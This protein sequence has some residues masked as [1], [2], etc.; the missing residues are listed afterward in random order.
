MDCYSNHSHILVMDAL[1]DA[2]VQYILSYLQNAK[3]IARC[4]CVSKQWKESISFIRSLYFSRSTFE[5]KRTNRDAIIGRMVT[6]TV[7]L[8]ELI[9]YC[10]F[11]PPSH[12]SWILSKSSSLRHLDLRVDSLNENRAPLG[13]PVRLD[14]IGSARG[15]ETLKLWG[16]AMNQSPNWG[17]F[18]RLH[19]LEIIGLISD[20]HVIPSALK[21]CPNLSSLILLGCEGVRSMSIELKQL[22]QCRLDF[23]LGDCSLTL[24]SPKLKV[25]DVLG[26]SWICVKDD[27]SLQSLTIGNNAGQVCKVDVGKLAAV[28]FLSLS[29]RQ[30]CWSAVSSILQSASE[31]KHLVMKIEFC[32]DFNQ[33]HCFPKI[34]L[35]EFF[36]NH[37]KLRFFEIHGA[38]FAALCTKNSS[39]QQDSRFTI[40]C[41]EE[42][43]IKVR[44][45]MN[46][47]QKVRALET[48]VKHSTKLRNMVI[49]LTGM[50]CFHKNFD[51][52]FKE[53]CNFRCMN[54]EIVR[55]E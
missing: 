1:P 29:G 53:I 34:D 31:V 26:C 20:D 21:A 16:V 54:H 40:P 6:S 51:N 48:I 15:L 46:A 7:C 18:E 45:P 42:V 37:P 3:D 8:E 2:L 14:C 9:V 22:E 39:K 32:G 52:F 47:E 28:D 38:M 19:S 4:T 49:R 50:N 41:L 10:P 17:L 23:W 12:E 36:N 35:F 25:L 27:H 30:W 24:S 5:N 33:L 43:L 44:S 11:S 55:I 13:G